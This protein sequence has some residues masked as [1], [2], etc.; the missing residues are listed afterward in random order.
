MIRYLLDTAPL[1]A[2]LLGRAGADMLIRPW[3]QHRAVA[4]SIIA[5]G[6]VVEYLR[7]FADCPQH[8]RALQWLLWEV[9][10]YELTFETLDRYADIR[11]ASPTARPRRD[12]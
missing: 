7:G 9:Q 10:P 2:L 1:A 11:R 8:H 12:R 5:Y 6:E 3:I 4:T